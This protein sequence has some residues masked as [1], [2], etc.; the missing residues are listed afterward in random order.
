MHDIT[1]AAGLALL[2]VGQMAASDAAAIASGIAGTQ[3]M[4][5]AGHVAYEAIVN[6]FVPQNTLVLCG[7]G[8]NGGDGW[9]TAEKL[10]RAGWPVR[11][12]SLVPR[13]ALKCDA[14][15]AASLYRGEFATLHSHAALDGSS[16][17][18][19]ALYGA[20]LSRPLDGVARQMV[21]AINARKLDCVGIDVPSGVHGDTGQML[22]AAPRCKLTVTFFRLKPGHLLLPGRS[23]CGEVVV[24]GIGIASNVLEAIHPT[25]FRNGP[26]LWRHALRPPVAAD[27]KYTR[28]AV[29]VMAGA[30]MTGAARLAAAAARRMGAGLVSILAPD[31]ATASVLR[32]SEPGVIVRQ[33]ETLAQALSDPRIGAVLLGPGGG[34]SDTLRQNV[35]AALQ[36]GR[37][38]VLDAD[39]LSVFAD[40]PQALLAAISGPCLLTPHEGEFTRL[41]REIN[42][43]TNKLDKVRQGAMASGATVLLKG[44][45]TVI[46]DATGRAVIND[47]APPSLATA[48]SG[49]VLAGMATGLLAQGLTPLAAGAAA[50]WL[51]GVAARRSN[52]ALIAEDLLSSLAQ[53]TL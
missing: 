53:T 2:T 32:A 27:H 48:G 31:A 47:N 29:L 50:A 34:V 40:N 38:A 24:G 35:L 25:A 36:T 45:D 10:R 7:P 6:R 13:E 20:G 42:S 17:V 52:R 46:A 3:L 1:P 49:D 39:A 4:A 44:A 26:A 8:N 41:F 18:I 14:A 33:G 28:G 11:V 22:G 5:A 16:L 15:W 19:D 12:A 30:G 51:H 43:S 9:V 37:P 23:L 21:E